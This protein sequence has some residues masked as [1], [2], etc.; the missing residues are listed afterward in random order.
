MFVPVVPRV[1]TGH[2]QPGETQEEKEKEEEDAGSGGG[3]KHYCKANKR[4][5]GEAESTNT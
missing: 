4:A 1:K 2:H 3:A 5:I